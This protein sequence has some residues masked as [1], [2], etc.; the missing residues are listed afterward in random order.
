MKT[1]KT[2]IIVAVV[3]F[4]AIIVFLVKPK[5]NTAIPVPS[6][7]TATNT[8]KTGDFVGSI[9]EGTDDHLLY[10]NEK[11]GLTFAFPKNWR[12]GDNSLGNGYLQLFN[13]DV[14]QATG[15]SVFP[16]GHNKIEAIVGTSNR[17]EQSSDYPAKSVN[18]QQIEIDG[19]NVTRTDVE[20]A[21]G[22]KERIY[23]I[24]IPT[25]PEKFLSV[26]IFGD[27]SNFSVLDD[28]VK[29]IRWTKK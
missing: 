11:I 27:V 24:L 15:K 1:N 6:P 19:Q 3:I 18:E 7:N 10:S 26:V 9:S 12:V 2:I 5:N 21:G 14:S 22:E 23:Y 17:Y 8:V 29:S 28:L 13:Y 16:A 25:D 20:L 4:L